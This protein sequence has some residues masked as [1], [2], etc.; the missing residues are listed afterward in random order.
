MA[1]WDNLLKRAVSPLIQEEVSKI[2]E[3][4]TL[5]EKED[6]V[7]KGLMMLESGNRGYYSPSRGKNQSDM[8]LHQKGIS[9]DTLRKFSLFYPILR[10]CINYRKRQIT[11]LAWDVSA[12]EVN[13]KDKRSEAN[14]SPEDES[15]KKDIAMVKEFLRYPIGDKITTFRNFINKTIEDA[16]V[17]DA[18]AIYRKKNLKG[19]IFGYVPIDAT[20]I[21]LALTDDGSVPLPPETA[22]IQ[23]VNGKVT[24]ELTTDD[25]IYRMMNPRTNTPFGL[26]PVE[27]LILTVSTALKLSSY[28]LAYLTEGN[29]PEG[30]VELP[31]DIASNPEQLKAW[32]EA[33]DAMMS[34]N[35]QV[36]RKIKFLPAGM[37]WTPT[38][39]AED[40]SF[41]RFEKWLLLQ[42]CSVMEVPPQAIGFQFDRGKGA[43]EAEWEIGKE[44]GL[45]PLANFIKE[46]MDQIIQEDLNMPHLEFTWQNINPTNKKEEADVFGKLVNT[47]AV[48]VDEW[49]LGEGLAPIGLPH[50]IMTPVGPILVRDFVEASDKGTPLIPYNY[51]NQGANATISGGANDKPTAPSTN[52]VKSKKPSG[53]DQ[54]AQTTQQPTKKIAQEDMVEEL[55]R[56]KKVVSKDI[57]AGQSFRDFK[58]DVIDKRTQLIIK[59]GLKG[60]KS[61]EDLDE[62][63]NPLISQENNIISDVLEL[64]G[65]ISKITNG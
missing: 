34:G 25:L 22:Y 44:R 27:T 40:M 65:N 18:V 15:D 38:K 3:E 61:K 39:E 58:S 50:F 20:T 36:R 59:D 57:K 43:T 26:S 47:G 51:Q 23:K 9:F 55:K 32:Q 13:L 56:W 6:A 19:G 7:E 35:N 37:K 12:I 2:R 46:I 53:F 54:N 21:E 28:N 5:K 8:Q 4:Y 45:Y 30:F 64:Y 11:Q 16:M 49:R 31:Q 41:E 48:S 14:M 60:V 17:L 10:A 52:N 62:L 42:T 1:L 63:F 24:A 29:V 33:W